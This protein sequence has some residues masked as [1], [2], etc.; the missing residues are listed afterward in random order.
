M[1]EIVRAPIVEPLGAE[2]ASI[3]T[4]TSH[5]SDE[6]GR[7][8][9]PR[10]GSGPTMV[11]Y[12]PP[13]NVARALK[14]RLPPTGQPGAWF[15]LRTRSDARP[16]GGPSIGLPSRDVRLLQVRD[17][18]RWIHRDF[19]LPTVARVRPWSFLVGIQLNPSGVGEGCPCLIR[20]D[21]PA[22]RAVTTWD[23]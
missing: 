1:L 11:L 19:D 15:L 12:Q 17:R 10:L 22:F 5:H 8:Y 21:E 13:A 9:R 23:R 3:G 14:E 18:G 6:I 20:I 7:R 2:R 4:E 16:T